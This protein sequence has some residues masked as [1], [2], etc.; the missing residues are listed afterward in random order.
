MVFDDVLK[1]IP[2]KLQYEILGMDK[3]F[4][5]LQPMKFKR[6]LDKNGNKITYVTS[7]YGISYMFKYSDGEFKHNFQ[8][9]IVYNGKPETWHRKA[10]Y[11]EETL[12]KIAENDKPFAIRI[13]NSL[14]SCQGSNN[15]CGERCLA[16][17]P[18]TFDGQK[19]L[20]CHGSVELDTRKKDFDDVRKFFKYLNDLIKQK[21]ANGEQPPEK[22]ILQK[23]KRHI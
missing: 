10:D 4:K 9:Y 23:A 7:E 1:K 6:V 12:V 15:C 19:R 2:E 14:K 11:M 22:I 5:S 16:R 3:Y 20:T 17:T 8:W 18:Y 21:I 13:Y